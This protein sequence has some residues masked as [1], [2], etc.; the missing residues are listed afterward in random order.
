MTEGTA[1]FTHRNEAFTCVHCGESVLPAESSC[2]NHCPRCL[3]S[4]HLDNLPGD[5]QA[6]CGGLLRPIEVIYHTKKGYQLV[7]RCDVCRY[8]TKNI[9]NLSDRVQPDSMDVVLEMMKRQAQR[10]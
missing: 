8:E 4:V 6:N 9:V 1:K 5:R 10:N 7:H 3:H 2:R